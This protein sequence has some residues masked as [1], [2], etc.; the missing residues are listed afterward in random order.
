MMS[1]RWGF[2]NLSYNEQIYVSSG[3]YEKR[4]PGHT[5]GPAGRSGYMIHCITSGHG[6]FVSNNKVYH[7][8]KDDMFFIQPH[9]EIMMKADEK[10]PWGYYWIRFVGDLISKYM[11]R[12]GISYKNPIMKRK[13]LPGVFS[14]VVGIAEYSKLDC[15][16][17]FYY[18]A[19]LLEI[20]DL[21]QKKY[22]KEQRFKK[23]L[24]GKDIYST[25][26]LYILNNYDHP[27]SI[28]KL[29]DKQNIERT[30]LFRIFKK[31]SGKSPSEFITALRL[32]KGI[33]LLKTPDLT[34]KE[35]ALASGF[36]SYQSFFRVFKLHF[37]I[38]PEDFRDKI[39]LENRLGLIKYN[40]FY[41]QK[42]N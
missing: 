3:G 39:A 38:S 18:Q 28:K 15:H 24:K 5:Y 32:Q 40:G 30:Y 36:P 42:D 23:I 11:K 2:N 10:D 4:S 27:L 14:R 31:N 8:G 20:L 7:L 25:A 41:R 9:K 33:E 13:S 12:I 19:Q 16:H 1:Y 37:N 26:A 35:V 21:L 17:D 6:I 22:P 29:A 34:I